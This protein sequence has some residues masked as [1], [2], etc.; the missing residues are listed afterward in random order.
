M[1]AVIDKKW[2]KLGLTLRGFVI[3][4]Y[5]LAELF[6]LDYAAE[7]RYLF[8]KKA[9]IKNFKKNEAS[10]NETRFLVDLLTL[11]RPLLYHSQN[12]E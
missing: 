11:Y 6:L 2:V 3:F 7:K 4:V 5:F 8:D 10:F 12:N 9:T 1:F